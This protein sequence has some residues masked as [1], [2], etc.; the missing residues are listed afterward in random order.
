MGISALTDCGQQGPNDVASNEPFG[1]VSDA[2][3]IG[4]FHRGAFAY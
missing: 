1:N 3:S 4:G 2:R